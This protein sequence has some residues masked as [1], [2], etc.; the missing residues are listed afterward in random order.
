MAAT[1]PAQELL[2]K[3]HDLPPEKVAEVVDFIDFLRSREDD[4]RLVR[5][6]AALSEHAFQEV[7]DNPEDAV[8][9]EL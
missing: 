2:E 1:D 3:L 6:T 7:W 9:D 8:Y 5:A 4:R